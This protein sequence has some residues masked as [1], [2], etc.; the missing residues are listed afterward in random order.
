MDSVLIGT[1]AVSLIGNIGLVVTALIRRNSNSP[2]WDG[3]DRRGDGNGYL[4]QHI[5]SCPHAAAFVKG[6]EGVRADI[7][8]LG[9]TL[10]DRIDAL[11]ARPS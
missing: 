3:K 7:S 9:K 4:A 1:L 11:Y 10:G 2:S 8:A 6:I 5:V